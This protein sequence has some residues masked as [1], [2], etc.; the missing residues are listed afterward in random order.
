MV[1]QTARNDNRWCK[2][3]LVWCQI[4]SRLNKQRTEDEDVMERY[5][6]GFAIK[7]NQ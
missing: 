4:C 7:T 2:M 3:P 6:R 5:N 1:E